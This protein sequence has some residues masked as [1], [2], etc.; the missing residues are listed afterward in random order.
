MGKFK[1]GSRLVLDPEAGTSLAAVRP[2]GKVA[3]AVGPEGGFDER[4]IAWMCAQGVQAVR[5][6]P[7]VL[8]TETAAPAAVAVLQ[9]LHG[10]LG[11]AGAD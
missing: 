11:P 6:G 2:E 10:D 1:D 5:L 7:R 9:C 4:E 3:L 8:R